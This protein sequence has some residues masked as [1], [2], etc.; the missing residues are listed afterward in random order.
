MHHRS[1][2]LV[3]RQLLA[4]D[5]PVGDITDVYFDDQGWVVRYLVV[6]TG[7]WLDSREVLISPFSLE[8][9]QSG[10]GTIRARLTREQVRN[11]PP[12]A[13]HAPVSRQQERLHAAYYG[14]PMYWAGDGL[15]GMGALPVFDPLTEAR[16]V[17]ILAPD[18]PNSDVSAADSHLRSGSEV[19]GYHIRA[20]DGDIG[21]VED[22][23][24]DSE[25]W[26]IE[27]LQIDTRNWLPGRHVQID[28][29]LI[30]S[31][32]WVE[33]VVV[34]HMSRDAVRQAAPAAD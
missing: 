20:E 26:R 25:T 28:P 29:A 8:T 4:E 1:T 30:G 5:E 24:I 34:V 17:A 7:G 10:E 27:A 12:I 15:W 18:E 33:R 22:F 16:Q 14:Y 11:S 31:V 32:D 23:L 9:V 3:G 6:D 19:T 2:E 21:H 13:T